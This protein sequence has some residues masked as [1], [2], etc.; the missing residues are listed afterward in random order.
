MRKISRL[1]AVVAISAGA[2]LASTWPSGPSGAITGGT[3]DTAN[4]YSN[5]GLVVFY[6]PDGRFRCSGTLIAP[7]VVLTAAHCTFQDIGKV[8]VTFDPVVSRTEDEAERD[9]PRA[10][11][12]TGPADAVSAIGYTPADVTT[13]DYAGEQTWLLGTPVTHPGYS[14]FTDLDNWNDTGVIIL[15]RAPG[16]PTSPIAPE[17]YLDR[18]AQPALNRTSFLTIGYGTEVR[19]AE[20]GPQTP[21]PQR[22]PIVRRFTTEIGQKLT[23]QVLQLNGN[24]NDPRA[25]GGTCFGDSGGPALHGGYVVGDTSYGYTN[26]CRY[27]G[28]YQRVDI[29]VVRNWILDCT[30]DLSCPTKD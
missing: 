8:A 23:D 12:D 13:P 28:G 2:V 5:V 30:S 9:I 3:E 18:F 10:S 15:D 27:L 24:E 7:R 19:K 21:T 14:D 25:D 22:Q 20:T 6:Q 4:Q 29:P 11:D 16:L 1:A 26:N 17:N